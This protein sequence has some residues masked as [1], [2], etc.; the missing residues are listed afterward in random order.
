MTAMGTKKWALLWALVFVPICFFA[1]NSAPLTPYKITIFQDAVQVGQKGIVRFSQ[2]KADVPL[3]FPVD[4]RNVDLIASGDFD[5]E[6]FR[7]RQDSVVKKLDVR[8]WT[9]ILKANISQRIDILFQIGNEYDEVSGDIRWV[10]RER[11]MVLLRG[12]DD[13]DYFIPLNQ[14]SQVIVE[15]F[16]A[17][18][19]DQIV[20][21]PTLEVHL[22][23]DAPFVPLEMYSLHTGITWEPVC[24][25]RIAGSDRAYLE[26]NAMVENQLHN[27]KEVEV[28]ISPGSILKEGQMS[29]DVINIGKVDLKK[30]DQIL[31]NY[32]R[33]ELKY[34]QLFESRVAWNGVQAGNRVQYPVRKLMRFSVP[35]TTS[36]S[37]NQHAVLDE[38]NRNIA[39][40]EFSEAGEDG[41]VELDLG[42]A[43]SVT[44]SMVETERKRAK[45]PV[46]MGDGEMI[47]VSMEGKLVIYNL[48][49]QAL[50]MDLGREVHGNVTGT[51]GGDLSPIDPA[52]NMYYLKWNI[53]VD[54]GQKKEVKYKY[55][56]FIPYQK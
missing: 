1:Q 33:V 12:D 28:E 44:V 9:D 56:A 30:G 43:K 2:S 24:R 41:S 55:D 46:K 47:E 49:N 42:E 16:S 20:V 53:S 37:C 3:E 14:I 27:F 13:S 45:K 39:N 18:K 48:S 40:I 7:F 36:F 23:K 11:G 51:S 29:G 38:N 32:R 5:V 4:P 6:W 26:M 54:P 34:Q 22:T 17:Y 35:P 21:Q 8:D 15:N 31:V 50:S 19:I 10:D 25:I 52:N